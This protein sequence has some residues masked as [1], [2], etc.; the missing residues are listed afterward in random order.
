VYPSV[1]TD[2]AGNAKSNRTVALPRSIG[3]AQ[4]KPVTFQ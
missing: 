3:N 2:A 4:S 1:A